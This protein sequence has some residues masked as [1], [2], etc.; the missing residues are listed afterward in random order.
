MSILTNGLIPSP[1]AVILSC[2]ENGRLTDRRAEAPPR[3]YNRN[4]SHFH[5]FWVPVSRQA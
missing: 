3:P 4:G 2:F 5:G 1:F